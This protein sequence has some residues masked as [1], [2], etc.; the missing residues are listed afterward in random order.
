MKH[1]FIIN[2]IAGKG[3]YVKILPNIKRV[4]KEENI[5]YEIRYITEELDGKSIALEYK[6][7]ENIIY[8]VGGDGTLTRILQG[9]IGTKNKLGV[10]PSGSGNDTFRTIKML[11]EGETL[12][13]IVKINDTYFI[14]VACTGLD[15]EVGNN[16]EILREKTKIP[17]SQLYNASIIYTFVKYKFKKIKIKTSIKEIQDSY[18]ILSICNGGYYGG[19]FNIAPKSQMTDGLLD[20]YYVEK[21]PKLRIIPLLLK[22]KKGKHEGKRRIHKFRTNNIELEFEEKVTFNIDGEKLT[23][24][25]FVIDVIPKAITIY[26]NKFINKIIQNK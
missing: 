20:I 11:P 7:G 16:V 14:N 8:S 21:M 23:D 25:N 12:V 17:A 3:K 19:G 15:A 5:D 22:L 24:N 9:I 4:C 1:I 2:T 18:S 6:D 26:N 13:D 10:I